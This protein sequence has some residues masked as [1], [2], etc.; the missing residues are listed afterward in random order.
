MKLMN[1]N[2][3]DNQIVLPYCNQIQW[4]AV[5]HTFM[6]I[7]D[8]EDWQIQGM[9]RGAQNT[10]RFF[11]RKVAQFF[12]GHKALTNKA[13]P[14]NPLIISHLHTGK[15]NRES[16]TIHYHFAFG[17]IPECITKEDMMRIFWELWVEKAKQSNKGIWLQK[18][19]TDNTGWIHYGHRENRLG[20]SLGLDI[21]STYIPIQA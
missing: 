2:R 16:S 5:G 4:V 21:H 11:S 19:G 13:H 7:Y 14:N 20:S 18:A 12:N 8:K 10:G 9:L 3:F 15:L 1:D 6:H 17:N